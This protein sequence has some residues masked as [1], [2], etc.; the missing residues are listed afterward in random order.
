[1]FEPFADQPLLPTLWFAVIGFFW[2]G[3][4]ILDGFDLGVG[5][6]MSRI[7]A[8][9]EKERRLLLNTIGGCIGYLVFVALRQYWRGKHGEKKL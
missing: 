6:L 4:I 8:K 5:M 2:V 9:N 7:F 3:Y 1:M